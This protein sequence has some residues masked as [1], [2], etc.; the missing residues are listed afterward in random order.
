MKVPRP[1][2]TCPTRIAAIAS[3]GRLLMRLPSY[4]RSPVER[5]MPQIA[6]SVVVL[7][8]PLAPR[9]AVTPPVFT[10]K[11]M[12]CSTRTWP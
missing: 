3:V 1:S 11:S 8:A 2:G 6:R 4:I 7:P 12:P 10:T 9:S 5:T